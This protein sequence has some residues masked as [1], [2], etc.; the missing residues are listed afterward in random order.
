MEKL[1]W[2]LG[3]K[4]G[5]YVDCV[6]RSGGPAL[7]WREEIEVSMRPWCQY[8]ID[9]KITYEGK[10]CRFSNIYGEPRMKLRHK[11]WEVFRYLKRHDDLPWLCAGDFNE[12]LSRDEQ[13]GGNPR[14]E[15]RMLE[16]RQCLDDCELTDLGFKGYMYTW[17]NKR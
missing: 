1:K 5:V 6:G 8:Y 15:S 10:T 11:T 16:F 2:R 12:A 7:W 4:N 13:L 17:N 9:A 14:N 3:F